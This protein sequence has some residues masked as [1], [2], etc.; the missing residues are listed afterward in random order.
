M[1]EGSQDLV[2]TGGL[3][4]FSRT[5]CVPV[6]NASAIRPIG[7]LCHRCYSEGRSRE[8]RD[9]NSKHQ[10]DVRA[11][12]L[13]SRRLSK[14]AIDQ[15][16]SE[17]IRDALRVLQQRRKEDTLRLKSLRVLIK[18][19]VDA[20][21]RGDFSEVEDA[22]LEE[23]LERLAKAAREA[24]ALARMARFRLARPAQLYLA[25]ILST[26]AERWGAEGQQRYAAVLAAA[27]RQVAAGTR[28][29][30]QR[31]SDLTFIRVSVASTCG[32]H[33]VLMKLQGSEDRFT[34]STIASSSKV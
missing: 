16:A 2:T 18:A 4:P 6:R 14:P 11:G 26:S 24:L 20:L 19:G 28:R 7:N 32:T 3:L 29:A 30:A 17:A 15:N 10:S 27:M 22:D 8:P 31:E 34:D 9:A 23:Y 12:R 5:E 25:N 33:S 13:L 1:K 21:D